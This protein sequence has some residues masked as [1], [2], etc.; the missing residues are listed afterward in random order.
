MR[1]AKLVVAAWLATALF[2][3]ISCSRV[4]NRIEV[5]NLS[6]IEAVEIQITVCGNDIV[7]N[8]LEPGITQSDS[9][10]ISCESGFKVFALLADGSAITNEFGY[11]TGGSGA[12]GNRIEIKITSDKRIIGEQL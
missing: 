5:V 6:G 1:L 7:F 4:Q 3:T 2:G 9:F 11:V 10:S 12:Y 8:D